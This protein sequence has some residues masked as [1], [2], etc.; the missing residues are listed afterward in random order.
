[1]RMHRLVPALAA[2]LVAGCSSHGGGGACC[3]PG[4]GSAQVGV[5]AG[6]ARTRELPGAAYAKHLAERERANRAADTAGG[7]A[8]AWARTRSDGTAYFAGGGSS[9]TDTRMRIA[10]R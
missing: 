10:P 4:G 8:G 1:M 3:G 2:L 9:D 7:V 5:P 6:S